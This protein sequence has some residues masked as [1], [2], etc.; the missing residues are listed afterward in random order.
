MGSF[1]GG[2]APR[3]DIKRFHWHDKSE[4]IR[5]SGG[6]FCFGIKTLGN[7]IGEL[8]FGP[9]ASSA[10]GAGAASASWPLSSWVQS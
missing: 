5:F 10:A 4:T 8:F 9:E 2:K 6:Q 1:R 7:A 3:A